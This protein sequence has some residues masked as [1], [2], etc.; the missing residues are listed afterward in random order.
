MNENK[1][2]ITKIIACIERN[3]QGEIYTVYVYTLRENFSKNDG[4]PWYK[5]LE[6]EH[7]QS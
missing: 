3:S 2:N 7:L 4:F 5:E 1:R 6:R